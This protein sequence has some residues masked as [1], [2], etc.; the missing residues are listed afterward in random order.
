VF[1]LT[2]ITKGATYRFRYRVKNSIGWTDF[3]P[4]TYILAA[5]VPSKPAT[6]RIVSTSDTQI[7]VQMYEPAD[8]GGSIVT[9]FELY[10]DGGSGFGLVGT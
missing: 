9:K 8:N 3:S 4:V 10:M 2:N 6:P 1:T 7:T 5:S